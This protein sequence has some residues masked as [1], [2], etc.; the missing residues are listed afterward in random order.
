V[1]FSCREG[2]KIIFQGREPG[3][4]SRVY[5]LDP[6]TGTAPKPVTPEGA[7]F[8]TPIATD[9]K[10]VAVQDENGLS[11]LYS[12]EGGAPK[13]IHGMEPEEEVVGM[14]SDGS[15][16]L[17]SRHGELPQKIF[18]LNS[19]T[20]KRQLWKE[21]GPTDQTGVNSLNK[22]S[23]YQDGEAQTYGYT[24]SLSELYLVKGLK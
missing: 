14:G 18:R 17:V 22:L 11:R 10:L 24:R 2:R 3:H 19:V 1:V 8:W 7:S 20:G 9:G 15:T 6:E 5:L 23:V 12:L 13:P 4:K 16:L 21:I